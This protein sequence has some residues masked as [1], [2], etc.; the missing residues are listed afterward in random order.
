[1]R[2][3]DRTLRSR[4][5][6]VTVPLIVRNPSRRSPTLPGRSLCVTLGQG[7]RAAQE[8]RLERHRPQNRCRHLSSFEA[9]PVLAQSP[10]P[11]W[12]HRESLM[13][14][15]LPKP[16]NLRAHVRYGNSALHCGGVLPQMHR[17]FGRS[18]R[19]SML[20]PYSF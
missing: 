12:M 17:S 3:Q 11:P 13:C 8:S 9:T 7:L 1:M 20:C 2:R 14:M 10:D 16:L 6:F 19:T 5:R 18:L 4:R 15:I